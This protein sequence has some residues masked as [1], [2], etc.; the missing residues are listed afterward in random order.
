VE[1]TANQ[2][3]L[4][5]S[6]T[7]PKV[8]TV[9]EDKWCVGTSGGQVECTASAPATSPSVCEVP[10]RLAFNGTNFVCTCDN[11]FSG[12]NCEVNPSL[13][14]YELTSDSKIQHVQPVVVSSADVSHNSGK[15][16]DNDIAS[17]WVSTSG[18]DEY[19]SF[20]LGVDVY[21]SG[22]AIKTNDNNFSPKNLRLE[23]GSTSNGPWTTAKNM[24]LIG[25][26][27]IVA[28]S[29]GNIWHFSSIPQSIKTR[30]A[31]LF[32]IDNYGGSNVEIYEIEFFR[33]N[34]GFRVQHT[35][36]AI[37]GY[38]ERSW[39]RIN[40]NAAWYHLRCTSATPPA[41]CN[42][43]VSEL[44]S[45]YPNY[46]SETRYVGSCGCPTGYTLRALSLYLDVRGY[47]NGAIRR[48]DTFSCE[49]D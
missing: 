38:C 32:I 22:L 16:T 48:G 31:R 36:G 21:I 4:S 15:L 35:K 13:S 14:G 7:D 47:N 42:G 29:A 3:L 34:L 10:H 20:D 5:Y 39:Y 33:A 23:Y 18:S 28:G 46:L 24:E 2:P 19:I 30:F 27:D 17:R 43:V 9:T 40:S 26:S 37:Y 25:P 12:V 6:E 49:K 44:S 41:Q 11:G 1:C 8:S 45:G